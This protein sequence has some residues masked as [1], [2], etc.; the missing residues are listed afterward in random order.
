M[1]TKKPIVASVVSGMLWA[2]IAV[3]LAGPAFGRLVWGGVIAAPLIGLAAGLASRRFGHVPPLARAIFALGSLYIAAAMF[4]LG[5]GAFDLLTGTNSGPGWHRIP[6]AVVMQAVW[7]TWW[8]LTFTGYVLLLWPLS[9]ANHSL[10]FQT[11]RE[12][13]V[14]NN[15]LA[16]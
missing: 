2:G 16:G 14:A 7:A 15:T 1:T 3:L 4:G 8:G 9:Y 12:A 10:I 6:S 13:N 5:V 11:W